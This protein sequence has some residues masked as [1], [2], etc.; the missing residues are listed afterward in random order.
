MEWQRRCSS[1]NG[2]V[3]LV[4]CTVFVNC[5]MKQ[6]AIC[7]DVVAILLLNVMEVFSV[8]VFCWI[9]IRVWSSKECACCDPIVHLSVPSID[10]CILLI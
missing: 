3:C 6:F 7:L 2:S 4:C 10:Q 9:D 5:L 1:V 8:E